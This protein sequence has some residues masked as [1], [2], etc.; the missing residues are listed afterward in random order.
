MAF[1][2]VQLVQHVLTLNV[3]GHVSS[4]EVEQI[5]VATLNALERWRRIRVFVIIDDSCSIETC[6]MWR[7]GG[8]IAQYREM[9]ERIA[10]LGHDNF[11]E[12]AGKFNNNHSVPTKAFSLAARDEAVAWVLD[13]L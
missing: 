7:D 13:G 2:I 3:A 1:E 9:I 11:S 12:A 8:F 10:I 4:A 5:R 6:P